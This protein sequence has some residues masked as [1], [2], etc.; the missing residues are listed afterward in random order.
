M[1]N[2]A[3]FFTIILFQTGDM[4]NQLKKVQDMIAGYDSKVL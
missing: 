4:K 1:E 2:P 3:L